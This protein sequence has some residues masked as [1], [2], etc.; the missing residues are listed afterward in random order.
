VGASIADWVARGV[1]VQVVTVTDG[2]GSHPGRRGLVAERAAEQATALRSLGIAHPP[3]RLRLPDTQVSE[4]EHD[5]AA[6]LVPLC[7][8]ATL[9]LAPWEHDGHADHDATGRASR[10]AATRAGVRFAAYPVWAWRWA[11]PGQLAGLGLVRVP[12]SP[13]A[14]HA[15]QRA[16]SCY[17]SQ[18]EERDG[19]AIVPADA[20][21]HFRR[22]FE[23][24]TAP[25]A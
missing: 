2:E 3:E 23:I 1:P 9:V 8:R 6:A 15:K 18:L 22:P 12:S 7:R 20:L 11:V 19:R 13:A 25:D 10:T 16:I 17:R 5:L 4:H 14:L 21:A 24:V